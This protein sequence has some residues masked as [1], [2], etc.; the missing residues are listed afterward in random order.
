LIQDSDVP[1]LE[2]ENENKIYK[3]TL[4][5]VTAT[6]AVLFCCQRI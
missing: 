6:L 2:E 3:V 4:L 1:L 5:I